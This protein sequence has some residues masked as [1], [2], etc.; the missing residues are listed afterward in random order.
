MSEMWPKPE[1]CILPGGNVLVAILACRPSSAV[2]LLRRMDAPARRVRPTAF[3]ISTQKG[4]W[5][6]LFGLAWVGVVILYVLVTPVHI[7]NRLVEFFWGFWTGFWMFGWWPPA[8]YFAGSGLWRGNA[9]SRGCA[10]ITI[11]VVLIFA[12]CIYASVSA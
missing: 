9:A 11:C 3:M 1:R 2:A 4:R 7:N 5:D 10:I 6:G 12:F 8:L